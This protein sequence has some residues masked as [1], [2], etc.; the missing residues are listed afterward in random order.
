MKE[1]WTK[2]LRSKLTDFEAPVIPDGLWDDI[3]A[4]IPHSNTLPLHKHY[5]KV[6]VAAVL[7]LVSLSGIW[8]IIHNDSSTVHH[9]S[10]NSDE[11]QQAATNTID[12]T[13]LIASNE[14]ETQNPVV[15]SYAPSA[16]RVISQANISNHQPDSTTNVA[17]NQKPVNASE[18]VS[19]ETDS[20]DTVTH[21]II[22]QDIAPQ[23]VTQPTK[24]SRRLIT[25]I[26]KI[27]DDK[28]GNSVY[29]A[30][31]TSGML[32]LK[33]T[34][35][36]LQEFGTIID[37]TQKD[38][39]D[40]AGDNHEC[41]TPDDT[42]KHSGNEYDTRVGTVP[43]SR[44][45]A[46][47]QESKDAEKHHR[48]I[49]V[50]LQ[51]GIP[52][53]NRLYLNTGLNYTYLYSE[54]D[55]GYTNQYTHTD[56]KIHY[57][58]IPLLLSYSLYSNQHINISLSGGGRMDFGI[59]GKSVSHSIVKNKEVSS[60]SESL[61]GLP[62]NVS[63]MVSPGIQINIIKGLSAYAEPSL[64]YILPSSSDIRTYYTTHNFIFDLQF[65]VRWNFSHN[66]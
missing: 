5:L 43:T 1:Q 53:T 65:G 42:T 9:I 11:H 20:E 36:K 39:T 58:G 56:Q 14:Q 10:D 27:L 45:G 64:Q 38:Q 44:K 34:S 15:N 7:L 29:L 26:D 12:R 47:M 46:K 59:S 3:N 57:I 13:P 61:S 23:R 50:G 35:G 4:K 66:R 49:S 51:I 25:Q 40:G 48:P 2:D 24:P 17:N 52:L 16:K 28:K 63:L 60:S 19:E 62:E 37:P 18:D 54:F 21:S 55:K 6:A 31:S 33:A 32:L 30:M 8:H 22:R 41:C